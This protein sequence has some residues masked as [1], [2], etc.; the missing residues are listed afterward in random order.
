MNAEGSTKP[1]PGPQP[2]TLSQTEN[3][4]LSTA[5]LSTVVNSATDSLY[6]DLYNL[7]YSDVKI[8]S[9]AKQNANN[10]GGDENASSAEDKLN[11]TVGA[12][13]DPNDA[14]LET[15]KA[16]MANLSFAQRRHELTRRIV[17]HT[18]SVA[19]CYALT[20]ASL[21][22][23]HS[24]L[25]Y[26]KLLKS[27]AAASPMSSSNAAKIHE[28]PPRL[29]ASVQVSSDALQFVKSGWISFEN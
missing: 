7:V 29:G 27:S 16:K 5:P 25:Q 24:S 15:R 21:P 4:A 17:Q 19:H 23:S 13:S 18:K 2:L 26:Q 8:V 10:T 11:A 22:E 28:P 20:A 14:L 6:Q 3:G 12:P 1:P 9:V